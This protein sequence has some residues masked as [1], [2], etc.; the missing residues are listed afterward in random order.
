MKF[1]PHLIPNDTAP[2]PYYIKIQDLTHFS[3]V[4]FAIF[5]FAFCS[6]LFI[7]C[8][9][10]LSLSFLPLSPIVYLL[11]PLSLIFSPR[12]CRCLVSSVFAYF[13]EHS[14]LPNYKWTNF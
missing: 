1:L 10:P 11:F 4:C 9:R 6:C 12:G 14:C 3:F 8:F 2:F 5:S 13:H 7:F